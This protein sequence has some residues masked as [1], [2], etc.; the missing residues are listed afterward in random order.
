MKRLLSILAQVTETEELDCI[1]MIEHVAAEA[2]KIHSNLTVE[3]LYD[4]R[5]RKKQVEGNRLL[6]LAIENLLRN[7]A[8]HAGDSPTATIE[9]ECPD[10]IVII[11]V[12]DDGPGIPDRVRVCVA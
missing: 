8:A 5:L 2:M 4:H 6:P 7:V 3:I 1:T 12:I 10:D 11:D 9:I